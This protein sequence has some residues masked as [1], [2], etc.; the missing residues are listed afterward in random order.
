MIFMPRQ[1][2]F[3][4]QTTVVDGIRFHS[5]KEA[6]YYQTLKILCRAEDPS[7]KI[8]GFKRQ[9]SY[10]LYCD[11]RKVCSHVVDFLVENLDG[12]LEVH[13]VKGYQDGAA[14]ALWDLKRKIFEANNP[15]IPYMVIV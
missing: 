3:N 8:K 6:L 12:S 15:K 2:K 10:D 14:Y 1:N 13:E 9:V 4:A 7:Q 5:K 11:G